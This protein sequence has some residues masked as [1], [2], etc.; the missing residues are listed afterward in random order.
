MYHSKLAKKPRDVNALSCTPQHI[1]TIFFKPPSISVFN[2][3]GK[4]LSDVDHKQLGLNKND[5]IQAINTID[6]DKLLLAVG[7]PGCVVQFHIY[8]LS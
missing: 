8:Q 1:F 7:Q 6:E 3:Q 5:C 2:I 4:H